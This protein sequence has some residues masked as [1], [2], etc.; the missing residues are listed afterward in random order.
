[1]HTWWLW[2]Q[3]AALS[4]AFGEVKL[5]NEMKKLTNKRPYLRPLSEVLETGGE[6]CL[7]H[8]SYSADTSS[9]TNFN[10]RRSLEDNTGV[11]P[12]ESTEEYGTF[13]DL[14]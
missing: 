6:A 4:K 11:T 13:N 7:L 5:T 8:G 3:Q 10:T 1:M 14:N 9:S 2:A 12:S